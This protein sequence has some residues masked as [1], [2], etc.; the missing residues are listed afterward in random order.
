MED[1]IAVEMTAQTIKLAVA[2]GCDSFPGSSLVRTAQLITAIVGTCFIA[3]CLAP[4]LVEILGH[5]PNDRGN[6]LNA[7]RQPQSI[8]FQEILPVVL[9]LQELDHDVAKACPV[10]SIVESALAGRVNHWMGIKVSQKIYSFCKLC[11]LFLAALH[12]QE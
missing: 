12:Y 1:Q 10:G 8:A 11:T 3:S 6:S 7:G 9:P 4:E 5:S 2:K